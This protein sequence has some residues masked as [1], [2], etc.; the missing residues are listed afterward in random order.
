[1]KPDRTG[2]GVNDPMT[3]VPHQINDGETYE[4]MMGRWSRA[5][6]EV[7]VDWLAPQSGLH[8]LDVRCGNGAFT[9]L[10]VESCAPVRVDAIDTSASQLDFARTRPA[11]RVTDFHQGDAQ[12]LPF[13]DNS[14]HHGV[15]AL[16]I[17]LIPEPMKAVTEMAR[18]VQSGGWVATYM[19]DINGGGFTMEPIRAALDEIGIST[20]YFNAEVCE[21]DN[22]RSLWI[23]VGLDDVAVQRIDVEVS[24]GDFDDFWLSH[25][26]SPNTVSKAIGNLEPAEA[27]KLKIRLQE[28]LP[29]DPMGRI[30]YGAYANAVRGK[31][32]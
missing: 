1:M 6:G 26:V 19:W 14:F 10:L 15:M 30:S 24:Y 11:A 4:R 32:A 12:S 28:M 22:L 8:W 13:D 29:A 16:V 5:A 20:P 9:E 23:D 7:F 3:E 21:M 2:I 31:A 25:T 17:N 27:E 18:V